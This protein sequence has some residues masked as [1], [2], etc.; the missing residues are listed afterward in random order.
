MARSEPSWW[1]SEQPGWQQ[2]VLAPVA[3]IYGT[4]AASRLK[5][6][7]P[8][9][10]ARP[11]I[12]VGNF[13]AGGTGK[14]PMS[15]LVAEIVRNQGCEPWFLSRGYG[16]RLDGQERVDTARHSAAEV[17]DEPLLLAANGPTVISRDRKLG[18]EFIARQAPKNAVIIMDDGLQNPA[19]AKDLTI[20]VV[21]GARGFGNGAVIP[22]GPLRAPLYAQLAQTDV[23]I[24]NGQNSETARHHLAG[25]TAATTVETLTARPVATGD[26]AWL[27]GARVVAYA[28]IA[29]PE[30]FFR[31]LE[32]LGATI[33]ERIAFADHQTIAESDAQSL[34][35]RAKQNN[36]TLITTAKDFVR[37]SGL[38]GARTNLRTESKT[39]AIKLLMPDAE[40]AALTAR[41]AKVTAQTT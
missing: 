26:T 4:I 16:G 8:Y 35:I 2:W 15:L 33:I 40:Y 14:T 28:G 29:N 19:L 38:D 13:T 6:T 17:G 37:L 12:C 31:L 39:L 24:V 20:A 41:I 22:A 5:R 18:A 30:R 34:L 11:V 3:T 36:A 23:I 1:Y 27:Q 7:T 25:V 21:D 32:S 9:R 10:A